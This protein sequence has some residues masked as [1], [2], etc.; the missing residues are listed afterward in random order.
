MTTFIQ[1][2]ASGLALGSLYAL[3]SISFVVL[4]KATGHFNLLPGTFIALGAYLVYQFSAVWNIPF[5]AAIALSIIAITV[6]GILIQRFTFD[7]I[8][9][10]AAQ[11]TAGLAVLLVTIGLL[12]ISQAIVI[13]VWG[14][15]TLNIGDPWGLDTIRVAGVALT[16]RDI[17]IIILSACILVVFWWV[18]QHTRVGVAMRA[19]ATDMEAALVQ[20]I[21]PRR[22]APV[23]WLMSAAAAVVAGTMM[24]TEAGGGLRPTLDLVAF[25]ALPALII[26]GIRSLPGC[27]IGGIILGLVQIYAVGYAPPSWGEG[28]AATLP[29]FI[30]IIILMVRPGGLVS[31]RDFRRA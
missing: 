5:F 1:L 30:L 7:P 3:V 19:L 12:S 29:W 10:R 22:V 17:W 26:G 21:N 16:Q 13:T 24:A 31:S 9:R 11:S 6:I 27:V 28:F 14:A 4:V 23:A 8:D 18:M 2:T 15:D 25:T 20:G